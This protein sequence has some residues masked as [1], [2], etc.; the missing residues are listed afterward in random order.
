M[1]G[2]LRLFG[3]AIVIADSIRREVLAEEQLACSV[4]I[5]PNKF[6]AKMASEV[7]KPR[8]GARRAHRRSRREGGRARWRARISRPD[9]GRPPLGRRPED[10]GTARAPRCPH[11]RGRRGLAG[12]GAA[13]RTRRCGARGISTSWLTAATTAGSRSTSGPSRSGTRRLTRSITTPTPR[14]T[15]SSA[16]FDAGCVRVSCGRQ[17]SRR[18]HGHAQGADE[19]FHDGYSLGHGRA[20]GPIRPAAR[21]AG[22][23]TRPCGR[24]EPRGPLARGQ[25]VQARPQPDRCS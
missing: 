16:A 18:T 14:S 4:G 6:L 21:G 25:R 15:P 19:R 13:Q 10:A 9:A 5:A 11:D 24:S 3:N 1:S 22:E 23:G 12:H 20:A 17:R 8:A 2:A 7:A